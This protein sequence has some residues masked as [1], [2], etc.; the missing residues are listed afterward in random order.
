LVASARR[1]ST[2]FD[3]SVCVPLLYIV[4][5]VHFQRKQAAEE[6]YSNS[7]SSEKPMKKRYYIL[8]IFSLP[9]DILYWWPD[10]RTFACVDAHG[11]QKDTLDYSPWSYRLMIWYDTLG[12]TSTPLCACTFIRT[13][14]Y[15]Q[16]IHDICWLTRNTCLFSCVALHIA[17]EA[18]DSELQQWFLPDGDQE[19]QSIHIA[20][21]CECVF[22]FVCG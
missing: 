17:W 10:N 7:L 14:T 12:N 1:N 2:L 19:F 3:M 18:Q 15:L 9:K 8:P 20:G 4:S 16:V 6:K 13:E 21:L 5:L 22:D 11:V